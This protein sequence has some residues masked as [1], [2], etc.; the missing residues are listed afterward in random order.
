MRP[1]MKFLIVLPIALA[2]AGCAGAYVGGDV[3]THHPDQTS[4][5][6][7][8]ATAAHPLLESPS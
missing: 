1:E 4:L 2:L 7:P 3:G 8:G 5:S 6:T